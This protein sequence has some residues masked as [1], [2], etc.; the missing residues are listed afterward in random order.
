MN[1]KKN[2]Y[3]LFKYNFIFNKKT[4]YH[5][6]AFLKILCMFKDIDKKHNNSCFERFFVNFSVRFQYFYKWF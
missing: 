5:K 2:F 6:N 1:L 4:I 3:K